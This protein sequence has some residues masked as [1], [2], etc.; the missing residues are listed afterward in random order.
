MTERH[1]R[2][3]I[4]QTQI[5]FAQTISTSMIFGQEAPHNHTRQI[6]QVRLSGEVAAEDVFNSLQLPQTARVRDTNR[7]R[8][9]GTAR[10]DTYHKKPQ[11]QNTKTDA[12]S[13]TKTR[14]QRVAADLN[15]RRVVEHTGVG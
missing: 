15:L 5:K 4:E 13:E 14:T 6:N 7:L 11:T 3:R 2:I 10:E 12:T 8:R 9:R 1:R